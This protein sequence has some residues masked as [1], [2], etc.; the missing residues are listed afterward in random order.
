MKNGIV[1]EVC[2]GS[3]DDAILAAQAGADRIELNM[4]LQFGG[5]TP[6]PGEFL[7]VR[8]RVKIPVLCMLRPRPGGFC[9]TD[10]EF[11]TILSDA[12]YFLE[13]GADGVVFGFLRRDGTV[14][15]ERCRLLAEIASGREAVFHRAF[16]VCR[17]PLTAIDELSALGVCRI[18]TS[19]G[20]PSAEEGIGEI[21]RFVEYA[22]GR[23]EI[24]AGG[25]V[26]R[27][28][29][30][31][32]LRETGCHQIHFTCHRDEPDGSAAGNPLL[33]FNAPPPPDESTFRI[34]DRGPLEDFLRRIEAYGQPADTNTP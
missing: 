24:L 16:D 10:A 20:K 23:L 15:T 22:A 9:Y 30:E 18:L 34:V 3:A 33:S 12:R 28:N 8:E 13:H 14:D 1:A 26:R 11:E 6:S 2:C 29:F 4:A 7:I 5:L 27:H 19:G 31:R 25:G 17:N 32:I 21:G